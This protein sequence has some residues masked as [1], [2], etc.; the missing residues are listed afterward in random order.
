MD[1]WRLLSCDLVV[2]EVVVVKH[3]IMLGAEDADAP[4]VVAFDGVA[5]EAVV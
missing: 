4:E 5:D 1:T 2:D 3:V